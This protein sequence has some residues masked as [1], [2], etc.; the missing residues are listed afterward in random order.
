M[1][2]LKAVGLLL[3]GVVSVIVL[4]AIVLNV[5]SMARQAKKYDI[6]AS[7][8]SLVVPSDSSGLERGRHLV[9]SVSVCSE[10]HGQDFGGKVLIDSP[11]M[12]K[13]AAS[14]LTHG[15][16]GL[17]ADYSDADW[18]RAIRHGV[19]RDRRSLVFM[20]SEGFQA[21]D[22]ADL[23]AVIAYMKTVPPV[24]RQMPRPHIGPLARMLHVAV[25]FPMLP[26][27]GVQHGAQRTAHAES[28]PAYGLYLSDLSGCRGC[29]GLALAGGGGPGP[30]IT[31]GAIGNWTQTD[32]STA[33][34]QGKAPG[35]RAL[36][37]EMPWKSF[38]KMTDNEVAALWEYAR[39]V[40]PVAVPVKR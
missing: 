38:S 17:P 37:E 14:N 36:S 3:I 9:R 2:V 11:P 16:G 33:V 18:A 39:S 28:G 5:V 32:F 21:M 20:P 1:Q 15:R 8:L 35:G 25:G 34:R 40:P 19:G 24:D 31:P 29:H 10:C 12:G 30:N 26:A 13:L 6:P 4:L 23:G 22:D 27:E 7:S